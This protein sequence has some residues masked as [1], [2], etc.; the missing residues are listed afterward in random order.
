MLG[1]QDDEIL[2]RLETLFKDMNTNE[3]TPFF[4]HRSRLQR[5]SSAQ[6]YRTRPIRGTQTVACGDEDVGYAFKFSV[7]L[8]PD[9]IPDEPILVLE[10]ILEP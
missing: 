5:V 1:Q 4:G 10:E 9:L 7:T 6:A 2:T 3:F 8:K